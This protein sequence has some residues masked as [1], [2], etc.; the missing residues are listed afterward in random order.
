MPQNN[1]TTTRMDGRRDGRAFTLIELLVVISIISLLIALLLPALSAARTTART[2]VCLS[3]LRQLGVIFHNYAIENEGYFP[4]RTWSD[5]GVSGYTWPAELWARGYV[6]DVRAYSC[7]EMV[8][9]GARADFEKEAD[10]LAGRPVTDSV[11]DED[12][13]KETHYGYNVRNIGANYRKDPSSGWEG[14]SARIEDI[15]AA[16]NTLLLADSVNQTR[17]YV[18]N[19]YFGAFDLYDVFGTAGQRGGLHARH[20]SAVNVQWADGHGNSN[21]TDPYNPYATLGEYVAGVDNI[22]TR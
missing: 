12:F 7:P 19:R 10:W 15:Q 14:P 3:N 6:K 20:A 2:A 8:V 13:W 21:T 4:R 1:T 11:K 17:Y 9:L 5:M 18:E 16:S 22:W